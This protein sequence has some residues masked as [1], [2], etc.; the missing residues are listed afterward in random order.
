MDKDLNLIL[1]KLTFGLATIQYICEELK[2]NR[3]KKVEIDCIL[4]ITKGILE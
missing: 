1:A 4:K 2:K 3:K